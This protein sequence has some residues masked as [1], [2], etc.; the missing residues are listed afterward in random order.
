MD[1]AQGVPLKAGAPLPSLLRTFQPAQDPGSGHSGRNRY[2]EK[3]G[4]IIDLQAPRQL[5]KVTN[6]EECGGMA[7]D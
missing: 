3:E 4:Q 1:P 6:A 7:G 2:E 5:S